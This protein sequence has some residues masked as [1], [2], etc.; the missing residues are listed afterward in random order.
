MPNCV[1]WYRCSGAEGREGRN[2]PRHFPEYAVERWPTHGSAVSSERCGV[3]T[4]EGLHAHEK[5]L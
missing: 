2:F 5:P 3:L 1:T 4:R